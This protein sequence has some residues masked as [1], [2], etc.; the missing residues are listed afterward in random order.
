MVVVIPFCM[1]RGVLKGILL[2]S[3]A[4]NMI[5]NLDGFENRAP[6]ITRDLEI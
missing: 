1:F 4:L 5:N 2:I 6:N 3:T